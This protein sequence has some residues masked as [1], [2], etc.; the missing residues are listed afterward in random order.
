MRTLARL[1]R[2]DSG[3]TFVESIIVIAI[4]IILSG[5]VSFSAVRYLEQARTA[6][7][8]AQIAALEL[9]LH[10][11]YLDTGAYP[12]EAQ[13]LAALWEKPTLAPT[14]DR[15][16]GPYLGR[17]LGVDPWGSA[18]VYRRPGP[19]GLAFEVVSYGADGTPGGS[20]RDADISSAG[21]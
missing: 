11:Y 12:T 19:A 5:T 17:P 20:G 1:D 14:P 2:T 3:W 6:S 18:F 16:N 13:G 4:I 10:S 9:S 8:R 21:R 7:A 15:W